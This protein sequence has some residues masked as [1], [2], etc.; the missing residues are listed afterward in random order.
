MAG[1][2]WVQVQAGSSYGSRECWYEIVEEVLVLRNEGDHDNL[3][4]NHI[5]CEFEGLTLKQANEKQ[6]TLNSQ[7]VGHSY[8]GCHSCIW[9]LTILEHEEAPDWLVYEEPEEAE[10]LRQ[11]IRNFLDK[12][13]SFSNLREAIK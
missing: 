1:K 6:H 12:R 10:Q 7:P 5:A 11:L 3:A 13:A 9:G 4:G 8:D 2:K